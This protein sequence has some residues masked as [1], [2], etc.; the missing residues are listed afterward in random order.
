M[1]FI[2]IKNIIPFE[3]KLL[4]SNRFILFGHTNKA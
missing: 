4:F 1:N 2:Y 3:D